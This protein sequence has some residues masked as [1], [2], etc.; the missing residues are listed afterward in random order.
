MNPGAKDPFHLERF[1]AAQELSFDAAL[2]ELRGGRKRTHWMWFIFPQVA[3]LG[4]SHMAV[5]YAIQSRAEG[6]AYLA[7]PLLGPRLSQCAEALLAVEGRTATEIMG[8]PD[9][10]KLKSSMTLFAILSPPGSLF[11]QVLDRYY[12]GEPDPRTIAFLAGQ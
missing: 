9:D 12:A 3:G 6:S 7:H 11:A 4:S 2:E 10:V 8:Q 1:V 5:R